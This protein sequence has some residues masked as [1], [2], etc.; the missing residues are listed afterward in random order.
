MISQSIVGYGSRIAGLAAAMLLAGMT[1]ARAA[2]AEAAG[3]AASDAARALAPSGRLRAAINLGNGVL[4]QRDAATGELKGVS[5]VLARAL[6]ERL[7]LPVDLIAFD[8]AGMVFEALDR[9]GWDVAFL[10]VEPERAVK[11]EFSPPYVL[12]EGTYMVRKDAP[13]RSVADLDRP[14]V[15]VS[16]AKGAAYDL[17]LSRT[18]KQ[19]TIERASMTG[20][21]IALFEDARLDAAAGVRQALVDAAR[22]R[23]DLRVLE[24]SYTTIAQALAV[25][26]GR[27]AAAAYVRDFIEEM[28]TSGRVRAAL[29]ATGQDGAVVAPPS[30]R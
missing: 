27:P 26:R 30:P 3:A 5:V 13:F 28:K 23:S 25:P 24:D 7:K 16:V 15:R 8:S 18:L 4:A 22:G 9:Q 17:Y 21:A 29:D 20:T 19:A 12:I 1:P 11:I 10:A 14:G 2:P 6:A